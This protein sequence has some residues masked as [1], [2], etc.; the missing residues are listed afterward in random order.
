MQAIQLGIFVQK[1]ALFS[2]SDRQLLILRVFLNRNLFYV[3]HFG[4]FLYGVVISHLGAFLCNP[5]LAFNIA[6]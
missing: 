5:V 3:T 2:L 4:A 1:D 6:G